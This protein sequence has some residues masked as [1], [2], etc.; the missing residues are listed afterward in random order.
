[1]AVSESAV[2]LKVVGPEE[3]SLGHWKVGSKGVCE[4]PAAQASPFGFFIYDLSHVTTAAPS[5]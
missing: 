4:T 2:D 3:K 5:S 1:M